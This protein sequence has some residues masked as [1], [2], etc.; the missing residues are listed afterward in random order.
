LV[1]QFAGILG[2]SGL[3][4]DKLAQASYYYFQRLKLFAIF[5]KHPGFKEENE[6]RVMYMRDRDTGKV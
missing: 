4:G 6:W 3:P 2:S 5:T 1:T